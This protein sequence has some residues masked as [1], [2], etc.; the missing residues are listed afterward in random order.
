MSCLVSNANEYGVIRIR[1]L[2]YI[3]IYIYIY[4]STI[5]DIPVWISWLM[6]QTHN[7]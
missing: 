2:T 4:I 7:L 1:V 3:Y 6:R 5:V